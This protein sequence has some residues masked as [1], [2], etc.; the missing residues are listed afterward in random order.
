[1][2]HSFE[3]GNPRYDDQ[4]FFSPDKLQNMPVFQNEEELAP[5]FSEISSSVECFWFAE[6]SVAKHLSIH[7]VP[8]LTNSSTTDMSTIV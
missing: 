3:E 7:H 1:M 4:L 6:L 8:T 5:D 2:S